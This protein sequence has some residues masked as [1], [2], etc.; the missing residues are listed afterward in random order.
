[1]IIWIASYPKSGNTWVRSIIASLFHTD[2]GIFKFENLKQ[3][4]QF[5]NRKFFKDFTNDFGNLNEIK[6]Y[7]ILAQDKINLDEKVK[8]FKTHNINCKIDEYSFTNR[9]NTLA[10]IY[11]VR[12]PRNVVKSISN[13]FSKSI[14]D[15]NKFLTTSNMLGVGKNLNESSVA[16][17]IG[18]WGQHYNFWAR[19]NKNLLLIKYEDLIKKPEFELEKI[20]SFLEK[21]TPIKTN[22]KKNQNIIRSTSFD[23]LKKMEQDG[24]FIEGANKKDFF[25]LGPN[26][27]WENTLEKNIKKELEKNFKNEMTEIGY[28]N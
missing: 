23:K 25:Y 7:W 10:T 28:L 12:D 4:P 6:K 8:F 16:T 27:K 5:P 19:N 13:H 24:L 11:V 22:A 20:I 3:V 18:S 2:D 14:V 17:L 21:L 9:S 15:A 26:N 1:M